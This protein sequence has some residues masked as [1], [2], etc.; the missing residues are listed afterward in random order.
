[1]GVKITIDVSHPMPV[2]TIFDDDKQVLRSPLR[3]NLADEVT[4][5]PLPNRGYSYHDRKAWE[6]RIKNKVLKAL[7]K[8]LIDSRYKS[9]TIEVIGLQEVESENEMP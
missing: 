4:N 5:Q 2:A 3:V 8:T 1:M 6:S 9:G 7:Q